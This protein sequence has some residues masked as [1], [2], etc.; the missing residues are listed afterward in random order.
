[1]TLPSIA[2]EPEELQRL[3]EAYDAAW[4]ALDG[5]NAIDALERSA[6]RERLGYIIVQVWQTDPSADLSTK[7]IQLF[8]AGMAQAAAP[9]TDA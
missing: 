3:A 6:A 8:R 7:A 4:T 9:R 1:M 2:A 5:Q